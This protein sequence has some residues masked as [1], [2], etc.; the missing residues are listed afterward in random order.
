MQNSNTSTLLCGA[1]AALLGGFFVLEALGIAPGGAASS[2]DERA[3]GACA[4]AMFVA[5]GVAAMLTTL[6]GRRARLAIEGLAFVIVVGFA[7][8]GG[9]IA[10]GPG[11]RS[12]GSPLAIF[13]PRVNEISGRIV[14]GFG[15]LVSLGV[16]AAMLRA[17]RA[18]ATGPNDAPD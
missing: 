12:F 1:I 17:G 3:V 6:P 7:A 10:I 15:A 8:I 9:W 4:G 13:G 18:L 2:S 5:G 16:A 11:E 14:F